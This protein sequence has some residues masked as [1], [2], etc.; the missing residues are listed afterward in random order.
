MPTFLILAVSKAACIIYSEQHFQASENLTYIR[1]KHSFKFGGELEPVWI[2]A[3]TTFFT[4]GAGIFSLE[5]FFGAAPFNAPPFGRETPVA[6]LFPGRASLGARSSAAAPCL[7]RPG[8]FA[9]PGAAEFNNSTN[10]RVLGNR[11]SGIH[12]QDQM[13]AGIEP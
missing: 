6:F 3:Q 4:P 12:A 8:L 13:E 2:D 10:L 11:L 1:G 9:G 5:S 7:S